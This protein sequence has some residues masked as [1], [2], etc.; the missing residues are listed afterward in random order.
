MLGKKPWGILL[1]RNSN[2]I[3]QPV[4]CLSRETTSEKQKYHSFELKAIAVVAF[5]Y[6]F[7]VT[8]LGKYA[9]VTGLIFLIKYFYFSIK[10]KKRIII[11]TI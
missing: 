4:S 1:Q 9:Y 10:S 6:R 2:N 5:L 7:Q 8:P 11:V 3:L